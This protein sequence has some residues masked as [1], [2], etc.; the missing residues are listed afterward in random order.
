MAV[1]N[2]LLGYFVGFVL[3]GL[4]L[5]GAIALHDRKL[6]ESFKAEQKTAQHDS[7]EAALAPVSDSLGRRVD[8][9]KVP[10]IVYRDRVIHDHPNDTTILQAFGKCDQLILTCEER[11]RVDSA[12]ISNLQSEVKTLKGMKKQTAP[13]LSAFITGGMDFI[14]SQPLIQAGGEARVIGPV[15]VTAFIQAARKNNENDIE[16][17]G[18]VGVRFTFR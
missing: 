1:V 10:Y 11:Q 9:I 18:V 12:R 13:R 7:T 16:T 4:L 17:R 8:S 2:K 6:L 5:W 14:A 3:G 15:S